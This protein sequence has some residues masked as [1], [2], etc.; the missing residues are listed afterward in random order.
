MDIW[1]H[2]GGEGHINYVQRKRSSHFGRVG[3]GKEVRNSLERAGS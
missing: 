1:M 2:E 3:D